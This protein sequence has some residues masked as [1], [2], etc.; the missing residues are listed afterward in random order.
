MLQA[1]EAPSYRVKGGKLNILQAQNVCILNKLRSSD[2]YLEGFTLV[3]YTHN[4]RTQENI[5]SKGLSLETPAR[6]QGCCSNSP[7]SPL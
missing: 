5:D 4:K 1:T 3:I 2:R 6:T 7:E